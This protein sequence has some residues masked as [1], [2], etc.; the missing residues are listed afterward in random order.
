MSLSHLQ[1]MKASL[2]RVNLSA[3][4]SR[5]RVGLLIE[6]RPFAQRTQLLQRFLCRWQECIT[7]VNGAVEVENVSFVEF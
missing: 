6:K 7:E 1:V 3:Y 4:A 2:S 5:V